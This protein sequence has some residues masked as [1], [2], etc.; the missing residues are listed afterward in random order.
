MSATFR[1]L[2]ANCTCAIRRTADTCNLLIFVRF[3][4]TDKHYTHSNELMRINLPVSK[5]CSCTGN[6]PGSIKPPW[7]TGQRR[8]NSEWN[9]P[10]FAHKTDSTLAHKTDSIL[11]SHSV[12]VAHAWIMKQPKIWPLLVE[13]PESH[14]QH[15]IFI[16]IR[17]QMRDR[18]RGCF[19][20]LMTSMLLS[21]YELL[22]T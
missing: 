12:R 4:W 22:I 9:I 20:H 7:N 1:Y 15:V 3:T 8:D 21:R 2:L 18:L 14:V 6:S 13:T 5:H 10:T 19:K 11:L 16:K 17:K